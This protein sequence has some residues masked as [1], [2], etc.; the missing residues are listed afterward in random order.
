MRR[1]LIFIKEPVSGQVKT[2]LAV[3]IGADAA[4]HVYRRCVERTLERL[5]VLRDDITLYVE[6]AEATG[7]IQTWL[8]S[9]WPVS[10]QR[11]VTL[12]ERMAQAIDRAF[13]EGMR[14]VAV[15]GTDSPW[16]DHPLIEEAFTAME[17]ADLV[18]GPARDGGYYLVGLARPTPGLFQGMP[19][20]TSQVLDQTLGKAR[21]LGLSV[22]LLP[23]GYDVDRLTDLQQWM[24][25]DPHHGL[26]VPLSTRRGTAPRNRRM[27]HA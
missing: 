2:R 8:G 4:C 26:T 1:L 10:P 7:R 24:Q 23:E 14:R 20:S 6:P 25:Q 9:E 19:W 12:G 5:A 3:E 17:Q 11:G 18:I 15:I 13:K 21:A 22:S 16:I 27:S